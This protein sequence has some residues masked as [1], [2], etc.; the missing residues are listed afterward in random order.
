M[1]N[2][3]S[4]SAIESNEAPI[5]R[6]I[7]PIEWAERLKEAWWGPIFMLHW[8]WPGAWAAMAAQLVAYLEEP[9]NPL[10]KVIVGSSAWSFIWNILRDSVKDIE[11]SS[12]WEDDIR[13]E[14][15]LRNAMKDSLIDV[16]TKKVPKIIEDTDIFDVIWSFV[17]WVF[18]NW[19]DLQPFYEKIWIHEPFPGYEDDYKHFDFIITY[20]ATDSED[21]TT[22]VPT[23]TANEHTTPSGWNASSTFDGKTPVNFSWESFWIDGNYSDY[24]WE[25]AKHVQDWESI[26]VFTSYVSTQENKEICWQVNEKLEKAAC[27][28]NLYVSEGTS[29]LKS[30]AWDFS[31]YRASIQEEHRSKVQEM[32]NVFKYVLEQERRSS[33]KRG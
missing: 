8:W 19:M 23:F 33:D 16:F 10:P 20:S 22:W 25:F 6:V 27:V 12:W 15:E 32:P 29:K 1:W 11:L 7:I 4:L 9:N 21:D 31:T 17:S 2:W 5:E 24:Q 28:S 18:D 26:I 14:N 3:E 13:Y 30:V